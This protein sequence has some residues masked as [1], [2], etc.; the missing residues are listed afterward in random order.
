[1]TTFTAQDIRKFKAGSLSNYKDRNHYEKVSRLV[2]RASQFHFGVFP[3]RE[4][5]VKKIFEFAHYYDDHKDYPITNC[6][7]CKK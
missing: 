1:M 4:A 2:N 6:P 5:S 3:S 7:H